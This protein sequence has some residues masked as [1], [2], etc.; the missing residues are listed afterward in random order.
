MNLTGYADYSILPETKKG[1]N[2]MKEIQNMMDYQTT[3]NNTNKLIEENF[4][5]TNKEYKLNGIIDDSMNELEKATFMLDDFMDIYEWNVR[6]TPEKAI[7]YGRTMNPSEKC[8]F[9]E[10]LSYK[11][12]SEYD[13]MMMM[14]HIA[15]DYCYNAFKLLE[16]KEV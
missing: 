2:A 16:Q 15:R 7:K 14:V 10:K 9:D 3:A 13:K 11:L 4:I 5:N 12:Y 8:T 6:P 1:R